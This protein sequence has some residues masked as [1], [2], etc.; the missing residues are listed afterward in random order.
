METQ[1]DVGKNVGKAE[2]YDFFM[3]EMADNI[4]LVA[5]FSP[6]NWRKQRPSQRIVVNQLAPMVSAPFLRYRPTQAARRPQDFISCIDTA[7]VRFPRSGVLAGRDDG[8]RCGLSS[9]SALRFGVR[10]HARTVARSRSRSSGSIH[11]PSP[12]AW[13][14]RRWKSRARPPVPYG[15]PA[16]QAGAG[17]RARCPR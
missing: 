12:S 6:S 9:D 4:G 17:S 15:R 11:S 7:A 5:V 1:N 3:G 16:A 8:V 2:N 14:T 13:L 10:R